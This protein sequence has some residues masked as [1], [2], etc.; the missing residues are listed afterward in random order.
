MA[1]DDKPT[2]TSARSRGAD[3]ESSA[4]A[5]EQGEVQRPLPA[6]RILKLA[7]REAL[8]AKLQRKFH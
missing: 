4:G 5:G 8:R 7:E 3:R 1:D 2:A 6:P